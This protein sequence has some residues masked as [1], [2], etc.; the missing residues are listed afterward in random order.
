MI[1]MIINE[2]AIVAAGFSLRVTPSTLPLY[3]GRREEVLFSLKQLFPID[4]KNSC[5][6][7]F[8]DNRKCQVKA[9]I[10][11]KRREV[12]QEIKLNRALRNE[13]CWLSIGLAV[14]HEN[15]IS[16]AKN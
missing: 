16:F 4:T 6:E 1:T 9:D 15:G 11:I 3:K 2:L 7:L 10:I 13:G 12:T 14:G 8:Q 5:S